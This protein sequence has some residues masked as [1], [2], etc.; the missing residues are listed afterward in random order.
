M[1]KVFTLALV[2]LVALAGYSQVRQVSY[3]DAEKKVATMQ[4]TNGMETLENVQIEPN[5]TRTEAELDYSTYDWQTNAGQITRTITW[6][7]GIAN[8]AYTWASNNSY[9]DRGTCIATYDSEKDEWFP[10]G[11]RIENERT[12]FGS[13]ARYKENGI[14]VAAHTADNLG[15]YI[16]ED[17]DNMTPNSTSVALYTNDPDF[18]HPSVMTSGTERDIIHVAAAK[19]QAWEDNVYEP[20]RYWRSSDGGQTWD[21][22]RVE[23]PFTTPEYGVNW[24]TNTYYWMETTEDNRIALV[25]NNT[26]SDGMVIYSDDN[27]ETWER[28]VFYHHPDPFGTYPDSGWGFGVPRWTSCQWNANGELCMAYEWNGTNGVATDENG[29]YFPGMGGVAYWSEFLPFQGEANPSYGYGY[30]PTN[31]MP[32]THGQPFIIDSAYIYEDLYASQWYW[33]NANHEMWPEYFGCLTT[34]DDDGFWEDP[35]EAT[36]WNIDV[37]QSLNDLHGHYNCG[38]CAMPILC[39]VPGTGGNDMVAVWMMMDEN[40]MDGDRFYFKLYAN[41][42]GDGGLTWSHLEPLT[43]DFMFSNTEFTYPQATVIGTTLVVVAQADGSPG[44]YVQGEEGSSQNAADNYYQ[45]MTFELNDLFPNEGVG[46][47]EVSHNT[48]M[49]LYPN[50]AVNQLQVVLSQNADIV[51]YNIMGQ[52]V[53]SVKGNAGLNSVNIS[54]LKAGVYFVNA[55]NDTQKLIVK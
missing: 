19:F 6:P 48:H 26:W 41:Y 4:K 12:G 40:N 17:K 14:V 37:S 34:L 42:S 33:S 39:M 20:I 21:K 2:L 16:V 43:N 31:P 24:G 5:M 15:I 35:Y 27:G 51:I 46:V 10:L 49:S 22:E 52:N 38:V 36:E 7:D 13:I 55:G 9:S 54:D 30:D 23:L 28:K 11:G 45:G 44:T 32:P 1:K 29:G 8:F 3:K 18:T 50:P 47:G 53:M 25:I